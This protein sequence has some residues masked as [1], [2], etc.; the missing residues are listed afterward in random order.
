[1]NQ[2]LNIFFKTSNYILTSTRHQQQILPLVIIFKWRHGKEKSTKEKVNQPV[3]TSIFR[4]YRYLSHPPLPPLLAFFT[5]S[6]ICE[7]YIDCLFTHINFHLSNTAFHSLCSAAINMKCVFSSSHSR[8]NIQQLF[9]NT[10]F[11][12]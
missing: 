8:L 12:H 10:R 1:M 3:F 11:P 4:L 5:S 7:Y 9:K 2:E 6:Y